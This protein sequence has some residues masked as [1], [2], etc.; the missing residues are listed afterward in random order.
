MIVR[1]GQLHLFSWQNIIVA[2]LVMAVVFIPL[3]SAEIPP[4]LDYHNHLAR[5]YIQSGLSGS[6]ILQRFYGVDEWVASPYLAMDVIVQ[7]LSGFLP[8]D[9]SG[10]VFL[11]LLL[12]LIASA[13]IALNLALFGRVTPFALIGLLFVHNS[14]LS[15]GFVNYLF[16]VG[17]AIC[18]LALWI[19]FREGRTWLRLS[20]FP[21]LASLLFFSHLLGWVIYGLS[22]VAYEFGRHLEK[23]KAYSLSQFFSLDTNQRINLISLVLQ[24]SIP[25]TLYVL[26]GPSTDGSYVANNTYGSIWRKIELLSDIFPYLIPPYSWSLDRILT[27]ALSGAT[28][29]LLTFRIITIPKQIR[30]PLGAMLVFFFAMPMELFGGWGADHRLLVPIGLMLAGTLQ[31][32]KK[33]EEVL[34]K[35]PGL[36]IVGPIS[37]TI[38]AALVILRTTVIAVE[39]RS[40]NNDV[41]SEYVRAFDSLADGS[42]VYFAF[43]HVGGKQLWPRPVYHLPLLALSRKK[44]YLPYL[45]NMN[46]VPLKYLP[47]FKRLQSLSPGPVLLHGT[48]PNWSAV[49][50]NYDFFFLV[51]EEFFTDPVP[52]DLIRVYEGKKVIVYKK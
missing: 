4:L 15:L 36:N 28:L 52:S 8:V 46:T 23:N 40:A 44:I 51:N 25:L 7:S 3:W 43:G 22:V 24:C 1:K 5:Q 35:N 45:F 26:Y 19:Q 50:D 29:L 21:I 13:P 16:S 18:L 33:G 30:W 38:I 34:A 32:G 6:D 31:L 42:K 2:A 37:M 27:I 48:S 14:T 12:L 47:E 17:F 11:S 49:I 41:Y 10:K 9:V 39:W 20:V